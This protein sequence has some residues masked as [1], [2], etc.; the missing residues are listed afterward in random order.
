TFETQSSGFL[1]WIFPFHNQY[2]VT[3]DTVTFFM[4]ST[5]KRIR[6][7][8]ELEKL[9][10]SWDGVN[11]AVVYD[12][13]TAIP[14]DSE[15]MTVLTMLALVIHRNPE[16][17]D[18]HW[19]PLEHEGALYRARF[20]W[21]GPDSLVTDASGAPANRYRLDLELRD[22]SRKILAHSDFFHEYITMD[23]LIKQVWVSTTTPKILQA[24]VT[25]KG[26]TL[27]ARRRP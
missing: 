19:Y 22:D 20:L 8:S 14:R 5:A 26:L 2:A 6:Q 13:K 18:T 11:S 23:G 1:D 27:K 17:F 16:N 12:D 3:F 25:L 24:Q 10:G 9:S 7:G 15:V 4:R 21:A